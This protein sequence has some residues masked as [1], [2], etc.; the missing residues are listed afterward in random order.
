MKSPLYT[1]AGGIINGLGLVSKNKAATL[2]LRLFTT[3][4]KGYV[5]TEQ[6]PFLDTAYQEEFTFE[7]LPIMTYRW[8]GKGKAILLVHGWESNSAR[9]ETLINAL[10]KQHYNI[11]ALDAP[12]HGYSGGKRFTALM[13]S[14][15]I[16]VITKRFKPNFI[17]SHSVGGMATMFA[18]EKY[19]Y[20]H[21]EKVVL[22]GAPSEFQDI[23]KRYTDMLSISN[24]VS[25]S[26]ELLILERF[27]K[28]PSEF[29][30][31]KSSHFSTSQGLIIHDEL[32][33]IIPYN[34]AISIQ[35]N[36]KN[37]TL[38]TTKGLGH[39]LNKSEVHHE[40]ERFISA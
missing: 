29:S 27:K 8:P 34:D 21:I 5:R 9:W 31:A 30:T 7:G 2:A 20:D 26:L 16:N 33:P 3:P 32:D 38:I 22:L 28:R 11:I 13:Y 35:N 14:E 24:R 25:N 10:K 1:L 37:S 39:S 6:R 19:Q 17:I 18:V 36:F 40:I 15:F 4:R 12:A 23:L